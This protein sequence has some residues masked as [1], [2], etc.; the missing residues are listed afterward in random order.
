V[1]PSAFQCFGKFDFRSKRLAEQS[2]K[3]IRRNKDRL[4]VA[5]KCPICRGW[6]VGETLGRTVRRNGKQPL[7]ADART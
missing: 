3:R 2:A 1:N 5:Y 7:D 6:H 4:V